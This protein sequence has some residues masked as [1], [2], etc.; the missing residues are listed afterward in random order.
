MKRFISYFLLFFLLPG[1]LGCGW[2]AFVIVMDLRS[3]K[4]ALVMPK[5]ATIAVCGDSQTKDG[6]DPALFPGFFNFSTAATTCDQD[7]LRLTDLLC[8]NRA[9][10]KYVLLD[11][12]PLKIGYSTDKPVSELNAG[13][14]HALL[15][16]YHLAEMRRE[17][18]SEGALWRDVVCT[19]KYNEFRKSILRRKPWRSS[20]AGGFDPGTMQGF[21]N[22]KLRAR[23]LADLATKADH[24]NRYPPAT[25]QE[26]F[27]KIL[28]ESIGLVRA[29]GATPVVTTMPLSPHLRKAIDPERL[30]AFTAAVKAVAARHHVHYLDYLAFDLPDACWHDANHLNLQGAKTFTPRFVA[31]FQAKVKGE[32]RKSK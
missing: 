29:A 16:L 12:S 5:T 3:Y 14:V 28:E 24:V 26:A 6:L 25:G 21:L 18:G 17:F 23:A 13:R 32:T 19:R 27:F 11:V 9:Q 7:L 1:V 8:R 2:T 31:D 30:S 10:V 4:R 22:P 20:M 15:Y